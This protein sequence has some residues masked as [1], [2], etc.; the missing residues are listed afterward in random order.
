MGWRERYP[1][2]TMLPVHELLKANAPLVCELGKAIAQFA[3]GSQRLREDEL[4]KFVV[5]SARQRRSERDTQSAITR[6]QIQAGLFRTQ[7]HRVK[8]RSSE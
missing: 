1:S 2:G 5:L 7:R 3:P 4:G 6:Q 8:P